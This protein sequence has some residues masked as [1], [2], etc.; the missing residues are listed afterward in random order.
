[1]LGVAAQPRGQVGPHAALDGG[2][3]K[4][5]GLRGLDL[6]SPGLIGD[7]QAEQLGLLRFQFLFLANLADAVVRELLEP[8]R[9]LLGRQGEALG[10]VVQFLRDRAE[11]LF[12]AADRVLEHADPPEAALVDVGIDGARRDE[13]DDRHG[14][15]LLAVAVDAADALLDPHRV[16]RQVVVDEEVAELEVEALAADFG[17]QQHVDRV[18][19][20]LGQRE[21]AAQI[22]P[23]LVRHI[24]VDQPDPQTRALPCGVEVAQRVAEGAEDKRLVVG[25]L[26]LVVRILTKASTFGSRGIEV[27][28]LLE[29]G[30]DVRAD[31]IRRS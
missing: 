11:D 20:F 25:Q 1:M 18:G 21:A 14:L 15:A 29:Q 2:G 5:E 9:A 30:L 12:A 6:I 28:R 8:P 27:A 3:R 22:G 17:R 13:V 23:L 4:P 10:D 7:I 19:I 26:A 31:L 24:A 16:P